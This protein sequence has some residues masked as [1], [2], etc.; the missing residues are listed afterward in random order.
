MRPLGVSLAIIFVS[1][2]IGLEIGP[3]RD[4]LALLFWVG[5]PI[6]VSMFMAVYYGRQLWKPA[7]DLQSNKDGAGLRELTETLRVVAAKLDRLEEMVCSSE[8]LIRQIERQSAS[9]LDILKDR[10]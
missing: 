2:W 7:S 10:R 1:M 6:G 8:Q 9:A 3:D 5:V 4:R